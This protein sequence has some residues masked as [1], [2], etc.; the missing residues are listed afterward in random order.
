[1]ILFLNLNEMNFS[2]NLLIKKWKSRITPGTKNTDEV[3]AYLTER[4]DVVTVPYEVSFHPF[5]RQMMEARLEDT[6]AEHEFIVLRF[7]DTSKN[8]P[9][10]RSVRWQAGD[11][12]DA[13][14]ER[15]QGLL[16]CT[17]YRLALEI[18]LQFGVSQADYDGNT[19][20]LLE[21]CAAMEHYYEPL[22]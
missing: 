7:L 4:Y 20:T 2:E 15:T 21:Y 11:T 19:E 6:G 14:F 12:V 9:I 1:M 10:E 8:A 5:R 18:A 22:E 16:E 3:I 17:H 13:V